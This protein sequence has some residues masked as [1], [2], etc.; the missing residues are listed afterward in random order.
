MVGVRL[1]LNSKK[2]HQRYQTILT[3]P[4]L[5]KNIAVRT[6][7]FCMDNT[8]PDSNV[9][10]YQ[11]RGYPSAWGSNG[12]NIFRVGEITVLYHWG[13][14]LHLIAQRRLAKD[15]NEEYCSLH[16]KV[17]QCCRRNTEAFLNQTRDELQTISSP[18]R[19]QHS[20]SKD[21]QIIRNFS[22]RTEL[23]QDCGTISWDC[24][25]IPA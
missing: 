18:W 6:N 23:K 21:G 17:Q 10:K 19:S 2:L 22:P 11:S 4:E 14:T 3:E 7:L 20:I 24:Q 8:K 5:K 13:D 12:K 16:G 25:N 9:G 15:N 1:I